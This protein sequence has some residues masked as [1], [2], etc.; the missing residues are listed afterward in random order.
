MAEIGVAKLAQE[1]LAIV[2]YLAV[3]GYRVPYVFEAARLI[4]GLEVVQMPIDTPEEALQSATER[5]AYDQARRNR[6]AREMGALLTISGKKS[7]TVEEEAKL[8][9]E[10]S[11]YWKLLKYTPENDKVMYE[12][13]KLSN[14]LAEQAGVVDDPSQPPLKYLD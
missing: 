10:Q 8:L 5:A 9:Y 14:T 3:P 4:V 1:D 7:H 13:W 6:D 2:D 11:E 12:G